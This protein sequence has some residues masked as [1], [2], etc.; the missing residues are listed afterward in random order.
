MTRTQ[1]MITQNISGRDLEFF[2]KKEKD[3]KVRE[4][5]LMVINTKEG[6]T[7]REVAK[8]LRKSFKTIAIW[9]NRFNKK[10]IEGLKNRKRPGK[11]PK[12]SKEQFENLEKDLEKKPIE[13]GYNQPFWDPKMLGI[14][15]RQHYI[16]NYTTRHVQRLFH[17]FGYSL[18][19]PRPKHT[20][21]NEKEMEEFTDTLK[22]TTRIWVRMDSSSNG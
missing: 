4:R 1:L 13:F 21:R 20:R 18:Q 14:H 3:P 6:H 11:P 7:T 12:M 2:Y 16:T 17:K 8:M 22:K 5:L 10:G 9:I 15:I 19:K